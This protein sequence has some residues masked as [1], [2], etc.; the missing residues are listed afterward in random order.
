[1]KKRM[2]SKSLHFCGSCIAFYIGAGF[3]TM[4]EV[5]QYEA[6]YG[7]KFGV[8]IMTAALIY[9]YTDLSFAANGNRYSLQHGTDIFQHYCG[10]YIGTFY[11][12][13]SVVFCY[14]CYIVMCG[15]ANSTATQQWGLPSGVGAAILM[16]A[17][18]ATVVFGLDSILNTLS[19]IGPVIIVVLLIV[20]IVA[21]VQGMGS[22]QE[23]LR[24]V[25]SGKYHLTQVGN[26]NP[27]ASGAS[28]GGFV[29]IWFSSFLCEI[30]A[31]NRLKEVRSGVLTSALFIFGV[32]ILCCI[33]L[34]SHMDQV[35]HADIPALILAGLI[36]P[37]FAQILA[38]I[39]F[40]GIY[41]TSV[42][43]LWTSVGAVAEDGSR[44]YKV[45]TVIGGAAG[46]VIAC[47][48][49]YKTLVNVFYGLNGYLG[50]ILIAFMIVQDIRRRGVLFRKP[51]AKLPNENAEEEKASA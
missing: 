46:C 13:F 36:S 18:I 43:L 34:I 42:P 21:C 27:F 9:I 3:A 25:D 10:K 1:M 12:W 24:A 20:S 48:L 23:N 45:L 30:G 39:V 37:W 19:K 38:I 29:V 8:V 31:K 2:K 50:F 47:F 51:D 16:I 32:A 5:M 44:K 4:Q 22:F 15:G 49:P 11:K 14:L 26:G 33:A 41:T 28:Y 7:S 40:C 35:A 6:S 17:V